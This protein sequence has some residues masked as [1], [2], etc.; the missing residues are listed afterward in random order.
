LSRRAKKLCPKCNAPFADEGVL[1]VRRGI[2]RASWRTWT[3]SRRGA[4]ASPRTRTRRRSTQAASAVVDDL[5]YQVEQLKQQ[6]ARQN[7]QHD[8]ELA[9]ATGRLEGALAALRLMAGELVRTIE[10]AARAV[11]R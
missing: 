9:D 10:E 3:P 11:V 5:D 7:E 1:P 8:T 4:S 6:L 2:P